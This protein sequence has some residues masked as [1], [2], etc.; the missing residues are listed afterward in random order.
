MKIVVI[1]AGN[2]ATRLA[3]ALKGSGHHLVQLFSRTEQSASVLADLVNCPFTTDLKALDREA[4][5]YLLA[6]TDSAVAET[7][8]QFD[9]GSRMVA[10]TA[11]SLS[12]EVLAKHCRNF[13]VFYPL[14]TFSKGREVSFEDIP[15][16]IEANSQDN[17]Q[18]LRKLAE[19]LSKDVREIDSLQRRQIH[20][21]AVFVCN[22]VNHF[23]AIGE[24][25]VNEKSMDFGILKPLIRETAMKAMEFSPSTVQ[26]GPAVRNNRQIIDHHL[27]ML[28]DH[29]DWQ[30]LYGLISEDIFKTQ[31]KE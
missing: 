28:A 22:F 8:E 3:L 1:G 12:I 4:D 9:F 21:S 24:T 27:T 13:G 16:C 19:S 29:P 7:T 11:G 15:I 30:E 20:L 14:Q 10:H 6:V 17:L 31:N 25:L 23:Y 2:L 5:L 26:T 18:T